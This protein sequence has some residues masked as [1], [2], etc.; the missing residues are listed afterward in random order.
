MRRQMCVWVVSTVGVAC[1][2][3][4][5]GTTPTHPSTGGASNSSGGV[6]SAGSSAG[7]AGSGNAGVANGGASTAGRAGGDA[8]HSGAGAVGGAG[9]GG[10][11]TPWHCPAGPF[12]APADLSA[13]PSKIPN[14]PPDDAFNM[15]NFTNVEGPVWIGDALY[16]SEMQANNN[17]PPS[18]VLK[19]ASGG[20]VSVAIADSG[21]NGLAVD[22]IGD[23]IAADHK[24]GSISRL[25][26]TGGAPVPLVSMYMG[27]R[28]NS[29]NDLA[30]RS[31]GTIYFSD[32]DFQA[33]T[34]R[35][36]SMTRL[37]RVAPGGAAI[38][39]GGNLSEPNGV[40]LSPDEKTLYVAGNQLKKFPVMT[41]GSLGAG[42]DF[43]Q[44]GGGSGDS[45][46]VDCAGNLYVPGSQPQ[47]LVYSPA[48]VQLGKI[49]LPAGAGTSTNV[50]FG[51]PER[52]T[53][54]ITCQ[55]N[56]S[57]RGVFKL[58]LNLP[59]LPY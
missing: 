47:V 9:G 35:P 11:T 28:F 7:G 59:G 54:Y 27:A 5:S 29:P 49:T 10:A 38:A 48:G 46:V 12:P 19:L 1:S 33:A 30:I 32:P 2:G 51:G 8:G 16:F 36:Q 44:G 26:L 21:S 25:S 56:A 34:P 39:V 22:T 23:L 4:G 55:G 43:V 41:D 13:T 50:A 15:N 37:Y 14:A 17:P 40:T 6:S 53:L 45:M 31:D 20:S 42:S 58:D 57:Q 3:G 52:K 18:R 24:D